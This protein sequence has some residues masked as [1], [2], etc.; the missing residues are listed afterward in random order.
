VVAAAVL[1]RVGVG[2]LPRPAGGLRDHRQ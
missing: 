2:R 1:F